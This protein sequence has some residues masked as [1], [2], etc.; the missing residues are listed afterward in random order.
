MS[1]SPM[2]VKA[3]FNGKIQSAKK[4]DNKY[5]RPNNDYQLDDFLNKERNINNQNQIGNNN[6]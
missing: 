2:N 3:E 4:Y 5:Q 1:K 6:N